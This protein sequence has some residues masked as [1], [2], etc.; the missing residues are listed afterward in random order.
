MK[1]RVTNPNFLNGVPELL[2]LS[3]LAEKKMYGYEL[4]KAIRERSRESLSF[5]EGSIYPV[6]HA[7]EKDDCL[8]SERLA[9]DGRPRFYYSLT[10]KGTQRL[11]DLSN[12]WDSAHGGIA[13]VLGRSTTGA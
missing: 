6:L 8:T 12:E 5:G 1:R 10:K 9:V 2:V 3:L 13:L 4:V 7:L 11:A